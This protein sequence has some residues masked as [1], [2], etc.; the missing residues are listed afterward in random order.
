[1]SKHKPSIIGKVIGYALL[2]ILIALFSF[3]VYVKSVPF[4]I[5]RSLR[6]I[7]VNVDYVKTMDL[8]N[9]DP[10]LVDYNNGSSNVTGISANPFLSD[11]ITHLGK[12]L[13]VELQVK[14]F[15]TGEL[16]RYIYL[17]LPSKV[18]ADSSN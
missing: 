2:A 17:I 18:S 1:M 15:K 8:S 3:C 6:A 10:A 4:G 7:N 5:P 12:K 14:D 13:V 11:S 16:T 9:R